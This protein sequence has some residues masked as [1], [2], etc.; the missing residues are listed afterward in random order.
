VVASKSNGTRINL[1]WDGGMQENRAAG[2]YLNGV[3]L[4]PAARL[5]VK[6][7]IRQR[8]TGGI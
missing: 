7:M 1:V 3:C 5:Q 2:D 6:Q 4:A 8:I